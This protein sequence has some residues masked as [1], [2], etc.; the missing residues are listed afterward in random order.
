C[1]LA[2]HLRCERARARRLDPADGAGQQGDDA[3]DRR[4]LVLDEFGADRGH[5]ADP[6][7]RDRPGHAC[8]RV[9]HAPAGAPRSV[10]AMTSTSAP[11]IAVENL[12]IRY[13]TVTAVE[14]ISFTVDA[15][16]QL[17]LLGPSGCG[18]TSTLRAVAGLER[19]T[20]GAI[21]IGGRAVYDRAAGINVR[22]EQRGMSMVFQSYAIWPHMTVFENVAYGLR[23]R[24]E[25]GAALAAQVRHAL[26]LVKM[27]Q[28]AGRNA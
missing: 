22:T 6:D 25:G 5:G 9:A 10:R 17:T 18:K 7:A 27:G 28:Y 19:P 24:K 26:D 3:R 4:S 23:V 11:A 13:G 16:Q 21:R 1:C 14:T 2:P 8:F 12:S 15:G 20:S